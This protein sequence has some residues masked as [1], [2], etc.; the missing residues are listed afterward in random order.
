MSWTVAFG[1]W[2][3]LLVNGTL[4]VLAVPL[5]IIF[6]KFLWDQRPAPVPLLVGL[7]P[8]ALLAL[9]LAQSEGIR[10]LGGSGIVMAILQ[11]FSMQ[12]NRRVGMKVI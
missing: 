12:H 10:Y 2:R 8:A 5:H 1:E 3:A 4:L 6:C 7:V 9:L 11:A